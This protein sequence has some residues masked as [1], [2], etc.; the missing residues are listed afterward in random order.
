MDNIFL[1]TRNRQGHHSSATV[2]FNHWILNA[3]YRLSLSA[4][5]PKKLINL[6]KWSALTLR[7]DPS[8]ELPR[9]VRNRPMWPCHVDIG[10]AN[11]K[12]GV[13]IQALR[14]QTVPK[15]KTMVR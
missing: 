7:L 14:H 11:V 9:E 8:K 2:K 10:S 5:E 3:R 13:I 4:N 12:Y 6:Y 1:L 15:R